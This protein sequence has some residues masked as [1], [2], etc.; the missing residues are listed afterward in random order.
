MKVNEKHKAIELRKQGISMGEIAKILNVAKSSVS[1]WVGDIELSTVQRNKLNRNGHSIESIEKRRVARITNTKKRRQ[2]IMKQ[3]GEEVLQLSNDPLWCVGVALY[4]GEGGKTQQTA[5][6]SNSDPA[7]IKIM[8]RF[9]EKYSCVHKSKFHAHVHTFSH[10]NVKKAVEYWSRISGISTSKFFKT[11]VKQ[12]SA[13][14]KKRE[15]LSYG[16]MQ[17]YIHDTVFFF[18]L[19]GWIDK[20]KEMGEK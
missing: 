16:T 1:N 10:K 20:L 4:W 2:L 13:S 5:R 18:R 11:Y 9:F 7:V 6:V 14:L 12:S 17:I 3:A 19:M 8:M 15:T